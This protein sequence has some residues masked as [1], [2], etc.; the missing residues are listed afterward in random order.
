MR[1]SERER[2]RRW[3]REVERLMDGKAVRGLVE[4]LEGVVGRGF[5]GVRAGVEVLGGAFEG[6]GGRTGA[7]ELGRGARGGLDPRAE[8]GGEWVVGN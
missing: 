6:G 7:G 3:R 8:V 1:E 2:V 4:G 5:E